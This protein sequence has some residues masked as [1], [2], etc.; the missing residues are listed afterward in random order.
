MTKTVRGRFTGDPSYVFNYVMRTGSEQTTPDDEKQ[1]DKETFSIKEEDR[2]AGT[3]ALIDHDA[4]IVPRGCY[5][6]SPK[7]TVSVNRA[8]TGLT[9]QEAR[10]SAHYM[11]LRSEYV[12]LGAAPFNVPSIDFMPSIE[13]K[14]ESL[15][16]VIQ[17]YRGSAQITLKN[18]YWEGYCFYIIP[19]TRQF[20]SLYVGL[21]EANLDLPFM[22]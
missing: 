2:L 18:L 4:V 19:N 22:V 9:D 7:H 12:E 3:V 6:C 8:W 14:E 5:L 1:V 20:G 10:N 16:W 21:G 15:S 13:N 11:H 17:E